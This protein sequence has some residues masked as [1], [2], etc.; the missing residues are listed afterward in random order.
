MLEAT[1]FF[2][3]RVDQIGN[4]LAVFECAMCIV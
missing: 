1:A 3:E 2:I 4:I